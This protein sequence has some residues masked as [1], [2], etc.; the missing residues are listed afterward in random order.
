MNMASHDSSNEDL[1]ASLDRTIAGVDRLIAGVEAHQWTSPTPCTEWNVRAVVDH[2][3][4]GNLYFAAL[5]RD[6]PRPDRNPE[7][8]ADDPID[9]YRSAAATMRAAFAAPGVL[10]RTYQSSIGPAPGSI[11]VHLRITEL[12]V[13]G[14][15]LARATGQPAELPADLAE[16]ELALWRSRFGDGLSDGLPFAPAQTV[17]A[18]APAI[19]RLAAFLGRQV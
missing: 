17:A 13:H 14:W 15:D 3:V 7:Q 6:E 19:D 16:Q 5:V 2:L 18:E 12:L 11:L 9:A 8:L 4:S 1:M 10:E